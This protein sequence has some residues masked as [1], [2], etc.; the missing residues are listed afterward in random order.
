MKECWWV[1]LEPYI[2]RLGARL[3][4][5]PERCSHGQGSGLQKGARVTGGTEQGREV[6]S[7]V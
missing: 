4:R 1:N 3:P 5:D 6:L 2:E 7:E